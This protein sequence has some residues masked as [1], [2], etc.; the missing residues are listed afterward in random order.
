MDPRIQ[1]ILNRIGSDDNPPTDAELAEARTELAEAAREA[2]TR[3]EHGHIDIEAG[4]ALR[5]AVATIDAETTRRTEA[6]AEVE[7]RA[8]ELL[9][10]LD[11]ADQGDG[12]ADGDGDG[13]GDADGDGAGDGVPD[14]AGD[15]DGDDAGDG[16]AGAPE[17]TDAGDTTDDPVPLAAALNT[18]GVGA[19]FQRAQQRRRT[20]RAATADTSAPRGTPGANVVVA[21]AGPAHQAVTPAD[22]DDVGR[23]F[24]RHANRVTKDRQTLVTLSLEYPE[25]RQLASDVEANNRRLDAVVSQRA[26]GVDPIDRNTQA[27]VAAG[28]ICAPV[29]ARFDHPICGDRGRPIRDALPDFAATRGGIRFAPTATVD[30]LSDAVSVWTHETDQEPSDQTKPCPVV[31][32][33]PEEEVFVDAITACLTIGNF[34]AKFNP[35]FW[36]S[37]LQLLDVAHD[38]LAEQTHWATMLSLATATTFATVD[39]NTVQTLFLAIDR[40]KAAINNRH[41]LTDTR[42]RFIAPAWLL[43]AICASI[44]RQAGVAGGDIDRLIAVARARVNAYF[45]ER[46]IDPVWSPDIQMFGAQ[47]VGALNNWPSD[48]ATWMLFPEGTFFFLDGGQIDLGTEIT[49]ST[50]NATNDRQAF[51]ETFEGVAYRGCEALAVTTPVGEDCV[52]EAAA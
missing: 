16:D 38:R 52:C 1:E 44:V 23:L 21:T 34:Q 42:Y 13:D 33:E 4:E 20:A 15:A 36:T 14:D 10:G 6:A 8:A 32:C 50:L 43:D 28:G 37:R 9:E 5:E 48:E 7:A 29:P 24:H 46:M 40:A 3:D 11:A 39:D 2:L 27:L 31:D 17:S 41:R 12:D 26:V 22:M 19:A 45:T 30:D 25:A 18:A 35:E 47:A 51:K 49:D